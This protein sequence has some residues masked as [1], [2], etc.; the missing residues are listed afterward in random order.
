MLG[1]LLMTRAAP[2]EAEPI[3]RVAVSNRPE[4]ADARLQWARALLSLQ[5]RD[6]AE[7]ALAPLRADP[8]A[9][10]LLAT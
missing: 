4:N 7:A 5:R 1:M 2:A 8:R 3:L 6:E 9:A 10:Q